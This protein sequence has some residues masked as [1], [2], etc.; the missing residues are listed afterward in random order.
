LSDGRHNDVDRPLQV[1]SGDPFLSQPS[2]IT[3]AQLRRR[4]RVQPP[5]VLGANQVQSASVEPR[6]DHL[7]DIQRLVDIRRNDVN[8]A[9]SNR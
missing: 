2:S 3:S 4:E 7:P 9:G 6:Y 1:Q 8:G 5:V